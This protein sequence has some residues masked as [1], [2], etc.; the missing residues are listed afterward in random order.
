MDT[1][2]YPAAAFQCP[3]DA[4]ANPS[5]KVAPD[6]LSKSWACVSPSA[7][8]RSAM[9]QLTGRDKAEAAAIQGMPL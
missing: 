6:I 3:E 4:Q 8:Q 1:L 5:E 9:H 7:E 2:Q